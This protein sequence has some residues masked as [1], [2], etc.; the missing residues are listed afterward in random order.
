M[1][2]LPVERDGV[3]DLELVKAAAARLLEMGAEHALITLGDKGAA[4]SDKDGFILCPA[5]NGVT[6]VD[7]TAAGDSFVAAFCTAVCCGA[8]Y[9]LAVE[10]ANDVA[11]TTV[12]RLGAQPSL[13]TIKEVMGGWDEERQA[14]FHSL[15]FS[16]QEV[17]TA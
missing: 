10:F 17:R 2:G 11:A 9:R 4:F 5:K 8:D 16:S 12:S 15:G 14:K 13:P 6:A 1:T 3:V 7:P